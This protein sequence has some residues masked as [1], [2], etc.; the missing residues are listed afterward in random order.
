VGN[1]EVILTSRLVMADVFG[2]LTQDKEPGK[3]AGKKTS[4]IYTQAN[5][6]RGKLQIEQRKGLKSVQGGTYICPSCRTVQ[7]NPRRQREKGGCRKPFGQ[8]EIKKVKS[9]KEN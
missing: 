6:K 4:I 7:R 9:S 5:K 8:K 3:W 2:I 1:G